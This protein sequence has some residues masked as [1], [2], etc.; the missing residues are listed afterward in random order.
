MNVQDAY[1]FIASRIVTDVGRFYG[2]YEGLSLGAGLIFRGVRVPV[3]NEERHVFM[4][5][6]STVYVMTHECDVAQENIRPFNDDVLV[7][8]LLALEN[9]VPLYEQRY[10]E[11]GL[12]SFL[13][14]V[15]KRNVSR[16]MYFPCLHGTFDY[17]A[18]LYLNAISSTKLTAFNLPNVSVTGALSEFGLREVD[19]LLEN[20]FLR[21]KDEPLAF[22]A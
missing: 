7:C 21:P 17:G 11:A 16:I 19:F 6:T 18:M 8:P 13:D 5:A 10:T 12:Q 14:N 1:T 15:A 4:T 3:Y 9:F 2:S 22:H 20:H